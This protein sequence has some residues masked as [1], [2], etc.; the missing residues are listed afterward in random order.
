MNAFPIAVI[1]WSKVASNEA[2]EKSA[3]NKIS[4]PI[5]LNATRAE[6]LFTISMETTKQ[7]NEQSGENS[8]FMRGVAVLASSLGS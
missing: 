3:S 2:A 4:L 6:L 7:Q 5:Y 1:K 8:F